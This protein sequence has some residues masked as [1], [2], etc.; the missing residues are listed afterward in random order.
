MPGHALAEFVKLRFE[1]AQS[2]VVPLA[3]HLKPRDKIKHERGQHVP[4][5]AGNRCLPLVVEDQ[6]LHVIFV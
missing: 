3:E 2:L 1:I 5:S 6:F 4:D